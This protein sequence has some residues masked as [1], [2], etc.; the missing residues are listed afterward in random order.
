MATEIYDRYGDLAP[1]VTATDIRRRPGRLWKLA[2][3][4]GAV[5]ISLDGEYWPSPY[6]STSLCR[7]CLELIPARVAR[8]ARL[9]RRR[10]GNAR[11]EAHVF[12]ANRYRQRERAP[13]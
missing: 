3:R 13:F 12:E 11:L 7:S 1:T 4:R 6:R 5:E 10:P 2:N 8:S 9:Q